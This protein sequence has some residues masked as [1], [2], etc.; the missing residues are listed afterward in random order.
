MSLTAY[1]N[2]EKVFSQDKE[3]ALQNIHVVLW[4]KEMNGTFEKNGTRMFI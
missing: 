2:K 3:S 1:R 4:H